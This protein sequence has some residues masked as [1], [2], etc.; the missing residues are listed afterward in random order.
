MDT[1]SELLQHGARGSFVDLGEG[2]NNTPSDTSGVSSLG[3]TRE[4]V[5][6]LMGRGQDIE[7][8]ELDK[9]GNITQRW[10]HTPDNH[11]ISVRAL[12]CS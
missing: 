4:G 10:L 7:I 5:T 9:S 6:S 2:E 11:V 1:S 12:P 3:G 8:T